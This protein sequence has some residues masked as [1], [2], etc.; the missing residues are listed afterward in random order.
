VVVSYRDGESESTTDK[1]LGGVYGFTAGATEIR[2]L[3]A[4]RLAAFEKAEPER[5]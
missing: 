4:E 2:D 5:E 1:T 3:M